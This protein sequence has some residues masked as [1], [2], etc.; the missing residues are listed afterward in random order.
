MKT[1]LLIALA[2]IVLYF[3]FEIVVGIRVLFYVFR[4]KNDPIRSRLSHLLGE[5]A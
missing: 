1:I 2:I 3:L 4:R 5:D